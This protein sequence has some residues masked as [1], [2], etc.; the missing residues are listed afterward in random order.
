MPLISN[1]YGIVVRMFFNDDEKHHIPH[2]HAEYGEYTASVDFEGNLLAGDFPN[3]KLKL[4][5]AWAEIHKEE[6]KALWD[7]MQNGAEYYKIKGLE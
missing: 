3:S 4:L 2:F 7:L 1:F 5:S 6:L